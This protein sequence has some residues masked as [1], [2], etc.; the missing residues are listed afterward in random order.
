VRSDAEFRP[1]NPTLIYNYSARPESKY[2]SIGYV[3][4]GQSRVFSNSP[5]FMTP[6]EQQQPEYLYG[7]QPP[8]GYSRT[9]SAQKFETSRVFSPRLQGEGESYIKELS[10]LGKAELKRPF[11]LLEQSNAR[12]QN[13]NH[14]HLQRISAQRD[15]QQ[16]SYQPESDRQPA[17]TPQ[18]DQ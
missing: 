2:N 15:S 3:D 13:I 16:Y 18:N 17:Q 6:L 9:Q 8:P 1:I 10:N 14:P 7:L 12:G 4:Q 11:E 5:T